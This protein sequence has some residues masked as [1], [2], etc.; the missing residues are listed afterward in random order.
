MKSLIRT[1]VVGSV[2][3]A[4]IFFGANQAEAGPTYAQR[5]IEENRI[6]VKRDAVKME[7][8][9]KVERKDLNDKMLDAFRRA[10]QQ[11]VTPI[12]MSTPVRQ[13]P[14][15]PAANQPGTYPPSTP[16]FAP[17]PVRQDPYE[18]A[19]IQPETYQPAAPTSD[20]QS[21]ARYKMSLHQILANYNLLLE[22]LGANPGATP[23]ERAAAE[24]LVQTILQ[25]RANVLRSLQNLESQGR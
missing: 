18:P 16:A 14:Y 17:A 8:R 11:T 13:D 23:E 9:F 5:R 12:P 21:D 3:G 1:F 10:Q 6:Q 4:S 2:V 20:A 22:S 7:N 15:E 24:S 19:P 25:S